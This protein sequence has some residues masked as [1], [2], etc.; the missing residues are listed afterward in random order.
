MFSLWAIL[1]TKFLKDAQGKFSSFLPN[2]LCWWISTIYDPPKTKTT[3]LINLPKI[4]ALHHSI[5]LAVIPVYLE[6]SFI[7]C[8]G[9]HLPH[10]T[11]STHLLL[12]CSSLQGTASTSFLAS[13]PSVKSVWR[14]SPGKQNVLI[15]SSLSNVHSAHQ[16]KCCHHTLCLIWW[17]TEFSRREW[18]PRYS[19]GQKASI[20]REPAFQYTHCTS[21][22]LHRWHQHWRTTC[23]CVDVIRPATDSLSSQN[24]ISR[25]DYQR[26]SVNIVDQPKVLELICYYLREK[27]DTEGKARTTNVWFAGDSRYKISNRCPRSV[28]TLTS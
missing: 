10:K 27:Q 15:T 6:A 19:S 3:I 25:I 5:D 11:S 2:H 17:A 21:F 18:G 4:G 9:Y 28:L 14:T 13:I 22:R 1:D 24:R 8:L 26:I 7:S 16:T 12:M 20:P 23:P